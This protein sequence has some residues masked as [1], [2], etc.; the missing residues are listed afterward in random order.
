MALKKEITLDNGIIVNYHRI[1]S[2]NK[3]TNQANIIEVASYTSEEKRA[4]EQTYYSNEE[5]N[6]EMNVFINTI[7]FN[8]EYDEN[9]TIENAY[10]Y[11]KTTEEFKD[12]END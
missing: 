11:L 4:E 12:A 10:D 9:E 6:K 1:V 5:T 2:L 3:I 8:K 7:Y